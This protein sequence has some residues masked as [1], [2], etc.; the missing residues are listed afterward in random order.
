MTATGRDDEP[1][2]AATLAALRALADPARLRILGLLAGSPM[3][4]E[5]LAAG[6]GQPAPALVRPLERLIAAELVEARPAKGGARF[7]LRADRIGA[8]ARRLAALDRGSDRADDELAALEGIPPEDAKVLR[9]YLEDGRLATIPAQSSK[10]EVV[11]RWLLD[12]VF[13]E[14]REY[15]EK[16]VNQ[17]IALVHPDVASLRRYLVDAGLVTREARRYRRSVPAVRP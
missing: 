11:L 8:I 5:A 17:L 6:V 3:T 2:D 4:R 15:P 7:A 14:D 10:R 13:T 16:E 12:L 1:L 9:G